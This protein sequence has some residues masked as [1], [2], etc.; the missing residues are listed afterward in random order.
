[1]NKVVKILW[2]AAI[3]ATLTWTA[4]CAKKA[5]RYSGFMTDYPK[6]KTGP[7]GG[8]DWVYLRKDVDFSSYNKLM[9]DFV[10]FW[11][12]DGTHY[13][14]IHIQELNDLA[15][16]FH[17]AMHEALED[18]YPL[19][20]EPG[21]DVL[22]IRFAITDVVA[23]RPDLNTITAVASPD[24]A[25]ESVKKGV[26]GTHTYV[27][28]ASMEAELLDSLTSER[29]GAGI[30]RKAGSKDKVGT[31]IQKWEDAKDAFDYWARRLRLWL[32]EV[33]GKK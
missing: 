1:M 31:G 11:F 23:T 15:S 7:E 26:T 9:L 22:R 2:V 18:T 3:C 17:K 27:G 14:G 13:K 19:V 5:V 21:P 25:D 24:S 8:L 33:H 16:S 6:F 29:L 32:D 4:G 12:K 10:Q 30:D 20:D 28:E